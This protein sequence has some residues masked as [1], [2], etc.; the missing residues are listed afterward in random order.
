MQ[1]M[2]APHSDIINLLC[3][4]LPLNLDLILLLFSIYL[5][6][7]FWFYFLLHALTPT[8]WNAPR[9]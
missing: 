9:S 8:H 7:A 6:V 5:F 4:Y 1:H 2:L 3:K